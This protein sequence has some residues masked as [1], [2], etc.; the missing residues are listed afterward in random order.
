MASRQ[1]KR[2]PT[3]NTTNI[4]VRNGPAANQAGPS[5]ARQTRRRRNRRK[6]QQTMVRVLPNKNQGRRRIFRNQGLGNRVVVQK[7]VST[8]GTVGANGSGNIETEMALL[9]N[10]CTMK[11]ATGSNSFGPLQIYAST[12]TLYSIRSLKLHLKPLVGG[13]AVSGT[14]V[15][16]SWNPTSNPTQTSWSALGAR[17]HSDTT[18]GRDGRLVLTAKHL[19]GPKD[20]WYRT[21]TKGEPMMAFAGSIE[22]HTLGKTMRTYQSGLYEG[23][24]FLAEMEIVWAFKDYS[25]Q[26]GLMNL[27]KGESKGDSTITTDETGKLILETPVTSSLARAVH[28]TTASEII[29]MVTDAVIQG[30]AAAF[31]PPFGW[32]IRGGWWFLKR[33]AG[34]PAR[35]GVERFAIYSSIND[36]R[37]DVPCI[38]DVAGYTNIN[39]G[40]LHFQQITPGNTGLSTDI[41]QV[42]ALTE[43]Y[44]PLDR[45]F[46]PVFT[47]R[48]KYNS[49]TE[50][51]PGFDVWYFTQ[52]GIQN[53]DTGFA[54]YAD[55]TPRATYNIME[56]VFPEQINV[57]AFRAKIPVYYKENR[58]QPAADTRIVGVAVAKSHSMLSDNETW[59]VDTFLVYA[60]N[61]VT[62]GYAQKWKGATMRYPTD[63]NYRATLKIPDTSPSTSGSVYMKMER[64]KWYAI[65]FTCFTQSA[66]PITQELMCGNEVVGVIPPRDSVVTGEHHFPITAFAGDSS[67]VPVYG[68]GFAFTPFQANEINIHSRSRGD[69][70]GETTQATEDS[71][72]S[73]QHPSFG[74]DDSMEFPPPP[75][76][77]DLAD[78]EGEEDEPGTSNF[79]DLDSD[80]DEDKDL[81]MGPDDHYSDPPISRLVVRDDAFALYEQLRATHSERA[82]RLAV[83]QLFPSDEYTEFTEVY[84]DAL[85]DGLSPKEARAQALGF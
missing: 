78:D 57:D 43:R 36:A 74:C 35:S 49:Q 82:A 45:T 23:G 39:V 80:L 9:L 52:Q 2:Q 3:R 79:Y 55:G 29:W 41:P 5:G 70:F 73:D 34:A 18:P 26:P 47:R 38:A 51:V 27:L 42:R 40:Q 1:Q 77:E 59:R 11:E 65:Q 17:I 66:Y 48:L 6:P 67:L 85:A 63:D 53:P 72:Y 22:I 31:P 19:K 68:A 75:S 12:Y 25:Q 76:E 16:A 7:I 62:K 21:N 64:G 30:A 33:L 8:L 13:S 44:Y 15:R 84:H 20:G 24:L 60:V 14:V 37:A 61:S 56:V 28:T 10:P 58:N 4:V 50:W 32:L 71:I 69:I 46:T 54:I 83:N 81:E